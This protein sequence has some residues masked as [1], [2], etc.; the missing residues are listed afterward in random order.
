MG[1][2]RECQEQLSALE[3]ACAVRSTAC[4]A[5]P[6]ECQGRRCADVVTSELGGGPMCRA[7][8]I[9]IRMLDEALAEF[10]FGDATILPES[11]VGTA[12]L[13]RASAF[14]VAVQ[15]LHGELREL[16]LRLGTT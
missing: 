15:S 3:E 11:S 8:A 6:A 9:D 14:D 5:T 7:K 10:G 16:A 12:A 1:S 2:I 13:L 4:T